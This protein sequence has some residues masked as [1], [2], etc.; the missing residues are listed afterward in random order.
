MLPE[1]S[2]TPFCNRKTFVMF[3]FQNFDLSDIN[4][5]DE[6][7]NR[8]FGIF[9]RTLNPN[10]SR[11]EFTHYLFASHPDSLEMTFIHKDEELV[12][13]CTSAAYPRRC[14]QKK[15][16]ILRSALG[17]HGGCKKGAFPLHG[18]FYKYMRYK[19]KHLFTPVYV[20]GFMANP[21]MYAMICRYTLRCYPKS[22]RPVPEK[23][24]ALKKI[25]LASMCPNEE[26]QAPFVLKVHFQ[27]KFSHE[28]IQRFHG[29]N[30]ENA[31]YFLTFNPHYNR[32]M[33]MLVIVPV[34]LGNM[35][36]AFARCVTRKL[37][38]RMPAYRFAWF[39][40]KMAN[41]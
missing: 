22:G 13:F 35:A 12:G 38:K 16:V 28:D 15:I 9:R 4:A 7:L 11:E 5:S 14:H 34:T 21:L 6:P 32:Q 37:R 8:L 25:I 17:L 31:K 2:A 24:T 23:I 20:A 3:R 33:G 36:Y 18:L 1:A 26:E 10:L 39:Q 40:Q 27:V 30:D 19:L 29:S 41:A